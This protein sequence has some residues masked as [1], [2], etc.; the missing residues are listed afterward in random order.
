MVVLTMRVVNVMNR[1]DMA[2]CPAR[3]GGSTEDIGFIGGLRDQY[4]VMTAQRL[5][6]IV[7]ERGG[8]ANVAADEFADVAEEAIRRSE[9][10]LTNL[11]EQCLNR[12]NPRVGYYHSFNY[13]NEMAKGM[14]KSAAGHLAQADTY[15]RAKVAAKERKR[16][17]M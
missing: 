9:E 10:K 15:V 1:H 3:P 13:C 11:A 4:I 17:S 7:A 8:Y 6:E 16:R 5:E 2:S 12:F 14:R